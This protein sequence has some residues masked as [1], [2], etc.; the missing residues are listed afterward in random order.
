MRGL[1]R[2]GWQDRAEQAELDYRAAEQTYRSEPTPAKW[3]R[4]IEAGTARDIAQR[5]SRP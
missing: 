3:Q 4:L 5:L 2:G 1:G